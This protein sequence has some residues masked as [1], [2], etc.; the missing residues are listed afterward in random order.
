M[1]D[2]TPPFSGSWRLNFTGVL[3]RPW[4][5]LLCR[6]THF[7]CQFRQ[8]PAAILQ[9]LRRRRKTYTFQKRPTSNRKAAGQREN[10]KGPPIRAVGLP[11]EERRDGFRLVAN[12]I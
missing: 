1:V 2:A 12:S 7:I 3:T 11:G 6:S 8:R 9:I 10:L 5:S 4:H